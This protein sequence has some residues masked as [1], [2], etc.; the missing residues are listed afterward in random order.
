MVPPLRRK[1]N[2]IYPHDGHYFSAGQNFL[3]ALT[4][5]PHPDIS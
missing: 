3:P 1:K 5:M 2:Y 4:V